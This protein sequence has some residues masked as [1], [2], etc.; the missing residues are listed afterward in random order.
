MAT[1]TETLKNT[2]RMNSE[3][4]ISNFHTFRSSVNEAHLRNGQESY[5]H[6]FRVSLNNSPLC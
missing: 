5:A 4:S 3:D 6:S 1:P 2:H